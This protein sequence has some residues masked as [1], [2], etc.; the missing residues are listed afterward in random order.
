MI[1]RIYLVHVN[2]DFFNPFFLFYLTD[3]FDLN[4]EITSLFEVVIHQISASINLY[5]TFKRKRIAWTIKL[6]VSFVL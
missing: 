5:L 4:D 6:S 1:L 3:V 2:D